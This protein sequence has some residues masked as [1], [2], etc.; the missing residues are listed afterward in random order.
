MALVMVFGLALSA[1][2]VL[3]V[4]TLLVIE[5]KRGTEEL[6]INLL[7][8]RIDALEIAIHRGAGEYCVSELRTRSQQLAPLLQRQEIREARKCWR[9]K[10]SA[11]ANLRVRWRIWRRPLSMPEPE[12]IAP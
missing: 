1:L 5:Y 4:A 12:D 9:R 7:E 3:I 10:L 11:L 8:L 2:G 6:A